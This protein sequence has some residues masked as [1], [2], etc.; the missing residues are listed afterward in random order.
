M[1]DETASRSRSRRRTVDTT[2]GENRRSSSLCRRLA[3]AGV[4]VVV[5]TACG[6][7][8]EKVVI[9]D[10]LGEVTVAEPGDAGPDAT[11][12]LPPETSSPEPTDTALDHSNAVRPFV[13]RIPTV[14]PPDV[15]SLTQAGERVAESLGELASPAGGIEVVGATCAEGGGEL[16]YDGST[17]TDVFDIE[18]DGSGIFYDEST[19]GLTTLEVRPDG[20]GRYYDESGD[21]LV[22]ISV[23]PDQSGEY[24]QQ[25]DDDLVTVRVNADGSGEYYDETPDRLLTITLEPDGSGRLYDKTETTLL[26]VDARGD[27]SGEYYSERDGEVTTIVAEADGSWE[28]IYAAAS[29]RN[30]T[31]RVEADGSGTYDEAG[32]DSIEFEFDEQ[33]RGPDG[34]RIVLSDPPQFVVSSEFPAL[35]TLGSL[36]PPCATVIRLDSSVL[37]DFGEAELRPEADPV[38]D[39]VVAVLAESDKPIDIVGHTDSIGTDEAN[40]VL[41]LER[42]ESVEAALRARGLDVDIS[43]DGRGESEPVAPNETADGQDDPA[44]R[45][46]NRRVDITIRE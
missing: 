46:Q 29:S 42:A 35:G 18:A 27:G 10:D 9:G 17:G 25:Q 34:E 23:E 33:G 28:Y 1:T 4:L 40:L 5:A 45:A 11:T 37:F 12:D 43:V 14:R 22:T 30:I 2:G 8:P 32:R 44:G 24:Y 7:D 41:S 13:P 16:D 21:G 6:P 31:L 36:A 15:S 3:V 20:T 26:T 19:D 38:L 39:E